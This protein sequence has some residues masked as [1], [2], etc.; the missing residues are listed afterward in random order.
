M[1]PQM[2]ANRRWRADRRDNHG[3][4]GRIGKGPTDVTRDHG[5][6]KGRSGSRR[7]AEIGERNGNAETHL[8]A[9]DLPLL[10]AALVS[11]PG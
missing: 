11:S 7:G 3:I 10:L 5:W 4:H 2:N 9:H 1:A 8:H 6:G